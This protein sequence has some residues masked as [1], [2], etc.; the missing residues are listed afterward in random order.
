MNSLV[1]DP[2]HDGPERIVPGDRHFERHGADDVVHEFADLIPV[3]FHLSDGGPVVMG[4]IQVVP[5]HFVHAYGEHG[6]ESGIDALVDDL[7]DDQFVD[8]KDGGMSQDRRSGGV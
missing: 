5:G 3:S 6:F 8:V 2:H 7:G 1:L 4:V